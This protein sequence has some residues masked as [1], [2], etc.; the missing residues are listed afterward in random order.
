MTYCDKQCGDHEFRL[1]NVF[2]LRY[3][4]YDSL[5]QNEYL[6]TLEVSVCWESYKPCAWTTYILKNTRLPKQ[7]RNLQNDFRVA[8]FDFLDWTSERSI[9]SRNLSSLDLLRLYNDL[10]IESYFSNECENS[11]VH[12]DSWNS[13]CL[14]SI[15]LPVLPPTTKCHLF[16]SCTFISCC[17]EVPVLQ[18]SFNMFMNL[19]ACNL[20]LTVGIE[21]LLFEQMLSSY[22]WGTKKSFWLNGILRISYQV[23]NLQ[24]AKK[25][26]LSVL[27]EVC[28]SSKKP[29]VQNI[30]VLDNVDMLKEECD[31]RQN[32]TIPSFSYSDWRISKLNHYD[33]S[34]QELILHLID[35][36]RIGLYMEQSSCPKHFVDNILLSDCP[37]IT[38]I[39]PLDG[40]V[41][42]YNNGH[43]S[44][45]DCCVYD[46]KILTS[47][48][49]FINIDSCND[50]IDGGI[51]KYKFSKSLLEFDWKAEH[52]IYLGGIYQ[53][54]FQLEELPGSNNYIISMEISICWYYE[55]ACDYR[56]TVLENNI[57]AKENCDW[58]RPFLKPG[59]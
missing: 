12:S 31:W 13:E 28:M 22:Q 14:A 24:Y 1:L 4:I 46:E 58:K 3:N 54:H 36:T 39:D 59:I 17:V 56:I 40:P 45:V 23:H 21:K 52:E 34:E 53:L 38:S 18:R 10:D 19:D 47:L 48:N 15:S 26:R 30:T 43:C 32:Y 33:Y 37:K 41:R 2:R 11:T 25:Y 7:P 57:L 51:E 6:V 16:N 49:V 29:C 50:V 9:D 5:H 8:D 27:L 55:A 44:S 42:C 35:E 20:K